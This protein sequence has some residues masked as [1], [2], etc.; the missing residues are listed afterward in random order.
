M[1]ERFNSM[2]KLVA[3][4]DTFKSLVAAE[5]LKYTTDEVIEK[6]KEADVPCSRCLSKDEVLAQEQLQANGTLEVIDHPLMGSMRIVKA[7]P[8]FGG[9]VLE[10]GAPSPQ[11]GEHTRSVLASFNIGE[12]SIEKVFAEGVVS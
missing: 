6:M 3:N 5:Y 11:H 4:I 1:D 10:P 7:P 8:R 9:E 2:E 12:D